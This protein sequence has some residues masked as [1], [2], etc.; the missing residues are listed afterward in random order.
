MT[1]CQ[2]RKDRKFMP[3]SNTPEG[4]AA[5][6]ERKCLKGWEEEIPRLKKDLHLVHGQQLVALKEGVFHPDRPWWTA[7]ISPMWP[8]EPRPIP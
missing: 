2:K 3:V 1:D 6:K 4:K 7:S 8:G 5:Q